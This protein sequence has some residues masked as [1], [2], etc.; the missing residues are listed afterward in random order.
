[1]KKMFEN[2]KGWCSRMIR[3]CFGEE[4]GHSDGWIYE[5]RI[6][7]QIGIMC[8]VLR[9]YQSCMPY[10]STDTLLSVMELEGE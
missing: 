1:M 8:E 2:R 3:G 4:G 6:Y 10:Y 9:I 7:F 5:V